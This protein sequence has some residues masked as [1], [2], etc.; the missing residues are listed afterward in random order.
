MQLDKIDR[1]RG[2]HSVLGC[3][4]CGTFFVS[5]ALCWL[6]RVRILRQEKFP[7]YQGNKFV[8][9]LRGVELT[10]ERIRCEDQWK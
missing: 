8:F 6:N 10:K 9:G 4:V 2:L 3:E 1:L 7:Q 5:K